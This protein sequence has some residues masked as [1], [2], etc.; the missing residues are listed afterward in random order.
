MRTLVKLAIAA[1]MTIPL[2]GVA[3]EQPKLSCVKDITY[4]KEF[5]SKFPHAGAAC[6]AVVM[7]NGQ[8][9]ARFNA[10][11]KNVQG[12]HLTVSFIDNHEN[13]VSTMTF[14]F[15]PTAQVTLENNEQKA[16]SSVEEGDKLLVWMPESR[17]GFYAKP[18]ALKSQ[19]FALVSDGSTKER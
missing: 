7:A 2:T 4:S 15:D 1:W 5:L 6:S 8:K 10:E 11:V 18:G 9:W 17:I 14:S 19:H 3:Q 16:A 12:N 13:P